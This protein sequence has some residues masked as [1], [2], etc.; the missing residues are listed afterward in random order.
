MAL[1]VCVK[2]TSATL[3][4]CPLMFSW[5]PDNSSSDS[6][7]ALVAR[8]SIG[9]SASEKSKQ[10]EAILCTS[11]KNSVINHILEEDT[12]KYNIQTNIK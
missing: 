8:H 9:H 1:G 5:L 7:R 4:L 11:S 3:S 12:R 10:T 6:L 2:H